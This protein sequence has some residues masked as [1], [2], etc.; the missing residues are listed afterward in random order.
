[1]CKCPISYLLQLSSDDV[2]DFSF[3]EKDTQKESESNE[4]RLYVFVVNAW[5]NLFNLE[6]T[7]V[8]GFL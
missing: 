2:V 6:Y 3:K 1:M 5:H 7:Q 8:I 4:R